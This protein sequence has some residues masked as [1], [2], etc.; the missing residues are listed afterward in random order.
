MVHS[1]ERGP[2][3]AHRFNSKTGRKEPKKSARERTWY[4]FR[5]RNDIE[6][7]QDV[8][9]FDKHGEV[10]RQIKE[11]FLQRLTSLQDQITLPIEFLGRI[12]RGTRK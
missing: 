5:L 8:D 10:K 7:K 11:A 1:E 12:L 3:M 2:V 4:R 6:T 9:R